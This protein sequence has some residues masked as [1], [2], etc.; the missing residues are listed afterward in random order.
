MILWYHLSKQTRHIVLLGQIS[1]LPK[2]VH[3]RHSR[4]SINWLVRIVWTE[5]YEV[6]NLCHLPS[7]RL[8]VRLSVSEVRDVGDHP[9]VNL[10]ES[11]PLLL[12]AGDGLSYQVGVGLVA[13]GVP[14]AVAAIVPVVG[15]LCLT[16]GVGLRLLIDGG[17]GGARGTVPG[18][19]TR[20]SLYITLYIL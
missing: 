1:K 17:E 15:R 10:T 3:R 2:N 11:H 8:G 5:H 14:P 12:G 13:P 18:R 16:D 20:T 6:L 7:S 19:L 9:V 4:I